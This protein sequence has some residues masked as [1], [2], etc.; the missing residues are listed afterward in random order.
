MGCAQ[1]GPGSDPTASG[2]NADVYGPLHPAPLL[3]PDP[4]GKA[5]QYPIL[6]LHGFNASTTNTWSFNGVAERLAQHAAMDGSVPT[7]WVREALVP[8]F[9][10]PEVRAAALVDQVNRLLHD[11]GAPK[12]NLVAHSMGG[13]DARVL[14]DLDAM[15]G[16]IA[17]LTTISSP[18]LGS[19]IADVVLQVLSKADTTHVEVA[20]AVATLYGLTFNELAGDTDL[21]AA[22]KGLSEAN[23]ADFNAAHQPSPDVYYQTWAGVST[24]TGI[25]N[26]RTEE[27]CAGADELIRPGTNDQMNPQL[28]AVSPIVGHGAILIDP[29]DGMATVASARGPSNYE[30]TCGDPMARGCFHFQGCFPADHLRD[31]GQPNLTGANPW[32]GFDHL[33]FYENLAYDLAAKGF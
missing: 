23:S 8:P 4:M 15:K 33:R 2:D 21:L 24:I 16:K 12:V 19:A 13:L 22:F 3:G 18:H 10:S 27:A 31:V 7:H 1:G 20:N 32:T 6:L 5:T 14:I 28:W 26:G 29:N 17:S 30:R 11:S 25:R 9:E